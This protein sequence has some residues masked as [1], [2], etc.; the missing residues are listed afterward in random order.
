MRAFPAIAILA[1]GAGFVLAGCAAIPELGPAPQPRAQAALASAASLTAPAAAWPSDRW[2]E[3]YGDAQ[4]DALVAEGLAG[5]PT[6]AEARA[7]LDA[8]AAQARIAGA[9][10]LPNL[11]GQASVSETEQSRAEGFPPFIQDLLPK[12]YQ[13]N[14]RFALSAGYDLDLFGKNRAALAAAVSDRAAAAAD[15]AQA[16]LTLST[17]IA[18]A[19]A[20]LGRLAAERAAAAEALSN[21][22]ATAGLV[23][24]RVSNGLDTQAELKQARAA[25]PTSAADLESLDEQILLARHKIAALLGAGPDRGLGI[26]PPTAEQLRPF[27]L[28]SD[29]RIGLVGRRP[30]LVAARERVEAAARRIAVA[31]AGFFPDV[32]LSAYLGRQAIGLADLAHPVSDIGSI[33]PAVTLPIFEGGA[34]RGAWRG[35]RAGYD[36]AVASYDQ[37]LVQAVQDV[38]DTAASVESAQRQL[39]DRRAAFSEGEAAWRIAE[40]RYRGGLSDYVSVLSAEDAVIAE[41][42]ALADAQA[43]AFSLDIALV[44]A[45]GGGFSDDKLALAGGD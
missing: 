37:T 35:A 14:G 16:R 13:P 39:A 5:S 24:Q 10:L 36:E 15:L 29:V 45:L 18:Q 38:A 2:W 26:V 28:P 3:R 25:A 11:E 32:S 33:G 19:Y 34:L 20:D 1:A 44:R 43:R 31:R 7:R 30:D 12:G 40:L 9:A 22:E 6:L 21:R 27:G 4:L 8:A 41:R 42:R 17:A 23:A